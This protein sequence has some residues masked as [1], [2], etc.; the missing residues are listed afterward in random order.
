MTFETELSSRRKTLLYLYQVC[1]LI[2]IIDNIY[3]M[4][5]VIEK[6]MSDD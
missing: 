1:P 6:V 2:D 5:K 4:K 3:N